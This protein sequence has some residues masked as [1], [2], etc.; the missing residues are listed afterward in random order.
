MATHQQGFRG[1]RLPELHCAQLQ[2]RLLRFATGTVFDFGSDPR[3]GRE[4]TLKPT[5]PTL[6][7][8][9]TSLCYLLRSLLSAQASSRL[10]TQQNLQ[11]APGPRAG[12]PWALPGHAADRVNY[13]YYYN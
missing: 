4:V 5:G 10:L 3:V 12:K 9:S 7:G 13:C 11:G 2:A 1:A 6:R 8:I